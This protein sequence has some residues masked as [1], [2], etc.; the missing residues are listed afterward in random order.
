MNTTNSKGSTLAPWGSPLLAH[1]ALPQTFTPAWHLFRGG[2]GG[3]VFFL[4]RTFRLKGLREGVEPAERLAVLRGS[5]PKADPRSNGFGLPTFTRTS[6]L[7]PPK[8]LTYPKDFPW[9]RVA[10]V[11][12]LAPSHESG[13]PVGICFG[14]G[15]FGTWSTNA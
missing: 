10:L 11:L 4:R 14:F 15:S 6:V 3:G 5:Q 7:I 8:K 1:F 9:F 13:Y 2:G 12:G